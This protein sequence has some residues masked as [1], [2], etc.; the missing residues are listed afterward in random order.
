MVYI[1]WGDW[2]HVESGVVS[3]QFC[4][5]RSELLK[6]D[7]VELHLLHLLLVVSVWRGRGFQHLQTAGSVEPEASSVT[8]H[9]AEGGEVG[10][11]GRAEG[12]MLTTHESST[13][14][15]ALSTAGT[16]TQQEPVSTGGI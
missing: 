6:L 14:G 4:Q 3:C 11:G 1:K 7:A 16:S 8:V 5:P 2:T 12:G 13:A 10:E 9:K 15:K